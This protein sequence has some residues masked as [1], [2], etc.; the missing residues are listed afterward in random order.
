MDNYVIF[1]EWHSY[2]D[3]DFVDSEIH[4]ETHDLEKAMR[5]A[6]SLNRTNAHYWCANPW[7]EEPDER[8]YQCIYYTIAYTD[9]ETGD[10]YAWVEP[11]DMGF[12]LDS[13]PER[14]HWR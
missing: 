7:I 5:T 11:E 4:G 6:L 13:I 8:M 1:K 3:M 14:P 2:P 9:D 12:D 10:T